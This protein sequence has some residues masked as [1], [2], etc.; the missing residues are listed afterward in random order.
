MKTTDPDGL[1]GKLYLTFKEKKTQ[2]CNTHTISVN[3]LYKNITLFEKLIPTNCYIITL[4][5]G[6]VL[7]LNVSCESALLKWFWK[8]QDKTLLLSIE[9]SAYFSTS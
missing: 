6:Y 4:N 2:F 1:T 3:I 9:K 7:N 5:Q 8:K